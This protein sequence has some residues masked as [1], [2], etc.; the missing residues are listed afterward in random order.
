MRCSATSREPG[1]GRICP[2]W[3]GRYEPVNVCWRQLHAAHVHL[4][5]LRALA[6]ALGAAFIALTLLYRVGA[7]RDVDREALLLLRE[8]HAGWLDALGAVDDVLF[9]PTPTF[10]AA[11]VLAIGL[12]RLGPRW[13]WCAPPAIALT[14]VA[15]VV[16]KGGWRQVL[17]LGTLI[18][19]VLVL[20]GGHYHAPASFPSGHVTR[21]MFLAVIALSLLPR[22]ASIP[23]ALLALTVPIAR[24]YTEAHKLSDVLGGATLGLCIGCAAVWGVQVIAA[25]EG[26][27]RREGLR[28]L[29]RLRPR[30]AA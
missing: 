18:D 13:S 27:L 30:G 21:A 25:R 1:A 15:E 28:L 29:R 8:L 26:D 16:T 10:A 24:M 6:I 23:F 7:T 19:G 22:K 4:R 3:L 17:H 14:A 9:R 12:W 20:F 11:L 2:V 5:R